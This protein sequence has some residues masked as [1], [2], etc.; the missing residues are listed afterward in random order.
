MLGR[1]ELCPCGMA[2]NIKDVLN[3]DVVVDRAG[4]KVNTAQKQYSDCIY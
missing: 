1:N 3:N 4:R 2:K